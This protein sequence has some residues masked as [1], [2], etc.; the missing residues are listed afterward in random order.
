MRMRV[1]IPLGWNFTYRGWNGSI[2]RRFGNYNISISSF[3]KLGN[4]WLQYNK[5]RIQLSPHPEDIFAEIMDNASYFV[6][7]EFKVSA[8]FKNIDNAYEYVKKYID[9]HYGEAPLLK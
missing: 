3:T 4:F 6:K 9:E 5:K 7:Y 1:E 2:H 8:W